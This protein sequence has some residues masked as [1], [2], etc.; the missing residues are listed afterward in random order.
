M[1]KNIHN[2]FI[3]VETLE[4]NI[5]TDTI[6]KW[7]VFVIPAYSIVYQSF[8]YD[9]FGISYFNYFNPVDFLKVFYENNAL[10][11]ISLVATSFLFL[12]FKINHEKQTEKFLPI[13]AVLVILFIVLPF[14]YLFTNNVVFKA[15]ILLL[16]FVPISCL[17]SKK[18]DNL[19][20]VLLIL[21]FLFAV[22][23]S[24]Y[25]AQ[26]IKKNKKRFDVIL[27]DNTFLLKE[28]K[29]KH[30]DYF[31]EKSTDY[32][33]IYSDSLKKVRAISTSQIKEIRFN[34]KQ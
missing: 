8:F 2:W 9:S 34:L 6:L 18:L 33:F 26:Q 14:L 31:I 27:N 11:L 24:Q 7:L 13:N 25:N 4:A 21:Y 5:K 12:F 28:I 29:T 3:K 32:I 1:I 10:L 16:F 17:W 15:I 20:Y 22:F 30:N 19:F 23:F